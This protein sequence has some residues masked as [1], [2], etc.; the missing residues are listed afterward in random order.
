M[1]SMGEDGIDPD[2][3]MHIHDYVDVRLNGLIGE[4]NKAFGHMNQE[5]S[6]SLTELSTYNAKRLDDI[7][8]RLESLESDMKIVRTELSTVSNWTKTGDKIF[9]MTRTH[10]YEIPKIE[11]RLK[12]LEKKKKNDASAPDTQQQEDF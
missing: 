11:I 1:I 5:V 8:R 12:D 4:I 3:N 6:N 2:E 9:E 10:A 7:D